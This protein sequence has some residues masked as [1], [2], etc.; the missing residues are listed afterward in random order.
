VHEA[1]DALRYQGYA[2]LE[3]AVPAR[4]LERTRDALYRGQAAI[5]A[6]LGSE[7]LQRAGERGVVRIPFLF[8]DVFYEYLTLSPVLEVVD[9]FIGDTAI[10]HLMNGFVLPSVAPSEPAI[11]QTTFHPDFPRYLNGYVAS[12]NVFVAIDAFTPENGATL[13]VPAT[14]QRAN[15]PDAAY[16]RAHAVPACASAGSLL[17]FD[18]TLWHAAGQNCSGRD[19]LAL[20]MQ[21][22]KS[23]LKQQIDYVRAL[24]DVIIETLPERTKQL[25]G[26]YTRVV[27][28]LDEYYQ[29]EE[30]RLYRRGQG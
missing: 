6:Q 2:I 30:K 23:F 20:N 29:P 8:D 10:L 4:L 19:R 25:L 26:W 17:L 3:G 11:F 9:A 13:M 15:A 18:S 24:G 27:T 21:F 5:E 22:T 14:H 7:R 1:L 16:M 12:L 28:T